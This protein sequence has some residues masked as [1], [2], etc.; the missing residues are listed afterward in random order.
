MCLYDFHG[1]DEQTLEEEC[2]HSSK[3]TEGGE[4]AAWFYPKEGNELQIKV[5]EIASD[6]VTPVCSSV[7]AGGQCC[8]RRVNDR[9]NV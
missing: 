1:C 6:E 3:S 9:E 2:A 5:N 8:R 7:R 4:S